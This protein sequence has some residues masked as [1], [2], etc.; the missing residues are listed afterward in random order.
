M[1]ISTDALVNKNTKS[2]RDISDPESDCLVRRIQQGEGELFPLLLEKSEPLLKRA[3]YR[4]FIKGFEREDLY[5]EA[6]MVLVETVEKYESAKGMS[7]N[8]Y[9]C[10]CLDNHFHRMIRW[11]NAI[12]R[13]SFR[14]SLSLEKVIEEQGFQLVAE[15]SVFMPA[16]LPII[17]ETVD[18]YLTCLS[19][20]ERAV[21]ISCYSGCSYDD[22]AV[23]LNCSRQKV[24]NAKHRC[25]D[26]FRKL[27]I[28]SN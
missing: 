13:Q 12:K 23:Q 6:C 24:I 1:Q 27:F 2:Y 28:Q 21:C 26:K 15:S 3:V 14:D 10:L 9:A 19:A 8:Q 22:T 25:T 17:E 5:Q 11:H 16:D 20:F 4:R 7:F 18:E